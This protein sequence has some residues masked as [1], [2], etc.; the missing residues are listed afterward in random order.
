MRADIHP[1]YKETKFICACGAS[2]STNSTSGGEI[3]TD[4]C[5]QCHPFFTGKEKLVDAA[6]R[7]EKFNRRYKRDQPAK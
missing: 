3:H 1:E 4:I 2:F 7:I 5:A 6:G